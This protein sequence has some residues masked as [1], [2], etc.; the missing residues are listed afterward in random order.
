MQ[1]LL[2]VVDDDHDIVSL[3]K[4]SLEKDGFSVRCFTDPIPALTDFRLH[5]VDYDLVM[6]DVRMPHMNGYEFV[7]QVKKLRQN[8]KILIISA[9]EFDIDFLSNFSRSDVDEFIEKPVSLYKLNEIVHTL[10]H[11]YRN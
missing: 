8:I 9:F 11:T 6:S 7:Q 10:T 2:L 4:I 1:R 3:I 5:S